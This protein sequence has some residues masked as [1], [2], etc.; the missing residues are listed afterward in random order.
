VIV[1]D[2]TVNVHNVSD[3]TLAVFNNIDP[4]RDIFFV[5]GPVDTLNHAAPE[6]DYG[7]KAGIDAT[8]KMKEEGY[9]RQWPD[10]IA[11]DEKT[12][13]KVDGMWK[14]LGIPNVEK[15]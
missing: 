3:V 2:K 15:S 10:E 12:K 9:A 5:E 6:R 8:A 1:V 14:E 7:S 11:M 13:K 4:K